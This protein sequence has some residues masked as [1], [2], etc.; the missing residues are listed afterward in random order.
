MLVVLFLYWKLVSLY[1][2]ELWFEHSLDLSIEL[3]KIVLLFRM[4]HSH[5]Q[6]RELRES[7]HVLAERES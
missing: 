6:E 4:R 1:D 3:C 2:C 5:V 7:F